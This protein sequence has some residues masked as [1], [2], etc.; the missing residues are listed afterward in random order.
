MQR[1]IPRM[2]ERMQ[3]AFNP[4]VVCAS[5]AVLASDFTI[6]SQTHP[7]N[8]AT[9]AYKPKDLVAISFTTGTIVLVTIVDDWGN[10]TQHVPIPDDGIFA[11]SNVTVIEHT[12]TD[13]TGIVLWF[14]M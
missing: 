8:G 14:V 3:G 11:V 12:T 1:D 5:G 10:T 7:V 4:L 13:A 2:I 9:V 6:A